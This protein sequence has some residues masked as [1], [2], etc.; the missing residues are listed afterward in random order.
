MIVY[1]VL[2]V[3]QDLVK[4]RAALVSAFSQ[5]TP[6]K[7]AKMSRVGEQPEGDMAS[8]GTS[9]LTR[10]PLLQDFNQ[11]P[12]LLVTYV[13]SSRSYNSG[14]SWVHPYQRTLMWEIPISALYIGYLWIIDPKYP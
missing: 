5:S 11:D 12:H 10:R 6:E 1:V 13:Q 7:I 2:P 14:D 9:R 8:K 4:Q 3:H